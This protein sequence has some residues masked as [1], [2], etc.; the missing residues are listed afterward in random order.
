MSTKK[1]DYPYWAQAQEVW[2]NIL[3][4]TPTERAIRLIAAAIEAAVIEAEY[5]Y[6][7]L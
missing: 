5:E 3:P 2:N 1:R 6:Y 4:A 7:D